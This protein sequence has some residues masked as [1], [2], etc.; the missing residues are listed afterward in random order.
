M[1]KQQRLHPR[2]RTELILSAAVEV[3]REKGFFNV[4]R[5]NVAAKAGCS[6]GIITLRFKTMPAL[7]SA[8]MRR[9]V[10]DKVLPIIGQGVAAGDKIA[11]NAPP[12]LR[13]QAVAS[14]SA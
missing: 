9:A 14:L 4:T 5:E 12:S 2:E 13:K 11:N 6:V 3:A 1:G 8:V 10:R 7:R